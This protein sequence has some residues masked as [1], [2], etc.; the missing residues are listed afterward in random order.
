MLAGVAV[1]LASTDLFDRTQLLALAERLHPGM[2]VP[3]VFASWLARAPVRSA[4]FVPML[5]AE[6]RQR[7]LLESR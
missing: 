5:Q 1:M 3:E 6:L 7:R 2:T 4:R